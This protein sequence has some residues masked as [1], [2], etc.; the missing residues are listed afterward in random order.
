MKVEVR[1]HDDGIWYARPYLGVNKVTGKQMRKYKR[2]PE[3][4]CEGEALE[5]ANEWA[6]TLDRAAAVGSSMRLVDVLA[7]YIEHRQAGVAANTVRQY[8]TV[9]RAWIEPNVANMEVDEF[10]PAMVDAL[11]NV[12]LLRGARDGGSLS[13]ATVLQV[14]NFLRGAFK[15]IVKNEVSP[16]NPMPSATKPR[17]VPPEAQAF[18]E[19]DFSRLR[20]ALLDAMR[21]GE[22]DFL[23][24]MCA[25]AAYLS[26]NTGE[27]CGEV[28]ANTVADARLAARTIHVGA[29][30]VKEPGK[31]LRR[32]PGTKG[33]GG[34]NVSISD[35]VC[36]QVRRHIEWRSSVLAAD[37]ASDPDRALCCN[38]RGGLLY[39]SAVSRWF[40]AKC[41]ELG[42][43]E[44]STFHTLRH[45]HATYLIMAG[46]DMRTVQERLGHANVTTTLKLY[47]H[48]FPGRDAAAASAFS[49]M[50]GR[51]G[52]MV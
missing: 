11:Y 16:F 41:G 47:T 8:R 27:R 19:V 45:T 35:D 42:F 52:G 7:S 13:P 39:P 1:Q 24:R 21:P 10:T 50:S 40:S 22:C 51:I 34:R 36:E 9:L 32:E 2:F 18:R 15:W 23:G 28:C 26:L 48:V 33:G 14:H 20:R 17:Y 6:A 25:F 44:G 49:E 5:M 37:V 31:P 38:E 12:L 4:T 30:V 3:A 29:R 46:T 43:P